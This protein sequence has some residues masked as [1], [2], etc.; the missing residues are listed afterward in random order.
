VG[1][2]EGSGTIFD[3]TSYPAMR[4]SVRVVDATEYQSYME[5]LAADLDEAQRSV[6]E[7]V[8]AAAEAEAQAAPPE[9]GE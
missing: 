6:E 9:E 1:I 5:G 2:Y 7:E 3:G 8:S 4:P